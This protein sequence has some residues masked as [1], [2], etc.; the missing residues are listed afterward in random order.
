MNISGYLK[1]L[2]ALPLHDIVKYAEGPPKNG[3]PF[4]GY[5]RQHPL[6]KHKLLLIYDPLGKN[7]TL[8]E[9]ILEDVLQVED[10]H[11]AV[12]KSGEGVPLVRLWIRRGAHGVILEPFEAD[13][14]VRFI[15]KIKEL[16][17]R[18]LKPRA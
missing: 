16:P 10:I 4:E 6:E 17:D 9:F 1:T 8:I 11:S 13:D 14:P 7:P 2:P 3:V 18:L 15:N 5:P 12:T